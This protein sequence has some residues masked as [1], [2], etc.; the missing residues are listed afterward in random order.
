MNPRTPLITS[1]LSLALA[2]FLWDKRPCRGL[3]YLI[4][5]LLLRTDF[6]TCSFGFAP[7]SLWTH[8]DS[9]L[10]S[11][12]PTGAASQVSLSEACMPA[13]G[14]RETAREAILDL[15]RD[16]TTGQDSSLDEIH[17]QRLLQPLPGALGLSPFRDQ[18]VS[19]QLFMNG[20]SSCSFPRMRP[21]SPHLLPHLREQSFRSYYFYTMRFPLC[22]S[23][24][25]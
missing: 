7:G 12:L 4:L 6:L 25:L 16:L 23:H 21:T 3:G 24:L 22:L 11:A 19:H 18:I 5:R 10:G 2:R 14:A 9:R 17:T 15:A 13:C 8:R 20:F 1:H